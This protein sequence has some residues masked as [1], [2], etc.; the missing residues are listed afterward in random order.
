MEEIHLCHSCGAE[1]DYQCEK[2]E[3]PV[4]DKCTIPYTQMNQID[5][6]LCNDCHSE[7]QEARAEELYEESL[8]PVQLTKYKKQKQFISTLF[9][10]VRKVK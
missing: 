3:Q 1:T 6:T 5:Y 4:C 9:K 7:Y 8:T 10:A 2:C